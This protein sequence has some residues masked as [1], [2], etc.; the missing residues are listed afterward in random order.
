MNPIIYDSVQKA[1]T[2]SS[3][4]LEP[5]VIV[6][7]IAA[8]IAAASVSL[9]FWTI[10]MQRQQS[11]RNEIYKKL[12]DFYGP[13]RLHLKSSLELYE[14]FRK[15]ITDRLEPNEEFSDYGILGVRRKVSLV[16]H[17]LHFHLMTY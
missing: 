2:I 3:T 8:L 6:A 17:S 14:V 15:S 9:N 13:I 5:A 12:N 7:L 16:N 1:A 10:K 4:Y 11:E